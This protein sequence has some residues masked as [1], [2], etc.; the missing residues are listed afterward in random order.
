VS[1]V[2]ATKLIVVSDLLGHV[3]DLLG[4]AGRALLALEEVCVLCM[5]CVSVVNV[6]SWRGSCIYVS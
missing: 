6:A 1:V 5:S 3:D 2:L 4:L